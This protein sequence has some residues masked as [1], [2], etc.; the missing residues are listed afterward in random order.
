[1]SLQIHKTGAIY[2]GLLLYCSAF[3]QQVFSVSFQKQMGH[4]ENIKI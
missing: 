4:L 2:I 3:A 1:M